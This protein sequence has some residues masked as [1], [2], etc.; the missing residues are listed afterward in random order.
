MEQQKAHANSSQTSS[1][2]FQDDACARMCNWDI[3]SK[4]DKKQNL[5]KKLLTCLLHAFTG[6]DKDWETG[7]QV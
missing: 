3:N 4:V 1:D 7:P 6:V 5:S 2:P